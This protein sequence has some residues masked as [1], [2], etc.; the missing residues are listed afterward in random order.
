MATQTTIEWT[1]ATWNPVSG[2][3]KVSP[4]CDN[5][6]AE[7]FSERFRGNAGHPFEAGF[8]LT[9]RPRKLAEPLGWRRPRRVFVNSM[10]DLFHKDIPVEFIDRV[11]DTMEQANWHVFQL[12]TKRS[13]LLRRLLQRQPSAAKADRAEGTSMWLGFGPYVIS[14]ARPTLRS[15]S[16]DGA[17]PRRKQAVTVW[18]A[19][20]GCSTQPLMTRSRPRLPVT[21][22][23]LPEAHP[24]EL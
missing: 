2:C 3:T 16:S 4:G 7:R 18:T 6:Y 22:A 13:S 9:L 5:C 12:L 23:R 8:D 19:T 14:V 24:H 21:R 20:N 17:E 11:F 15:F 10:S 1:D